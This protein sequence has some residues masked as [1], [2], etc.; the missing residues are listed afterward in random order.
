M[1]F[2][3]TAAR[4]KMNPTREKLLQGIKHQE[5]REYEK[6]QRLYK[7]VLKKEPNNIDAL[8]LYGVTFRQLGFPKRAVEFIQKAIRL[9]PKPQAPFYTNLAR[10]MSDLPDYGAED[11]LE[12]AEKAL[13]LNPKIGEALNLKAVS[14]F[15]LE[16]E[17]EAEQIFQQLI[18]EQPNYADTYRNYGVMLRDKED[19]KEALTLFKG[20]LLLD[21]DNPENYVDRSRCR[22]G[23]D[24]FSTN[25][26]EL[27]ESLERFPDHGEVKHEVARH[28]FATNRVFEGLPYAEAAVKDNPDDPRRQVTL[29]VMLNALHRPEDALK[30]FGQGKKLMGNAPSNL[31]WN[32]SLAFM[33]AGELAKAWDLHPARFLGKGVPGVIKRNFEQPIWRGEDISDKTLLIW[34]DQ[35][36]GDALISGEL[37]PELIPNVGHI[38]VECADKLV[39]V[40]QRAFPQITVRA[41]QVG[42]EPDF[43]ALSSDFDYHFCISDLGRFFRRSLEDYAKP[44]KPVYTFDREKALRYF[45][46]LGDRVKGPIV[47]VGWRSKNLEVSRTRDYLS[48]L[49]FKDVIPFEGVT[50]LN[51]QYISTDKE[52]AYLYEQTN[53][54]FISFDDVDLYNDLDSAMALSALCDV[55]VAANTAACMQ[56]SVLGV[57]VKTF[58]GAPRMPL[59]EGKY[60][61]YLPNTH[62]TYLQPELPTEAIVPVLRD[63][64]KNFLDDF[65]PAPRLQRL[66]VA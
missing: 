48:V 8:H 35:G 2:S 55:M 40:M 28:M 14:L 63:E 3:N 57:P 27:S 29:G 38:I 39:P 12:T 52:R 42:P 10:A 58:G 51:L 56:A 32:I 60:L 45:E 59:L 15:Q 25:E 54:N 11:V 4:P 37:L 5:N 50:Y 53:G 6:A 22:I 49:K 33:A 44:R 17:E 36:L 7:A 61:P 1:S 34:T 43:W 64:L 18:V 13:A 16:R 31:D 20:A 9:S 19:F 62:H 21:P 65:S 66:G 26:I 24:D 46:R 41:P 23:L 47:G 30:A